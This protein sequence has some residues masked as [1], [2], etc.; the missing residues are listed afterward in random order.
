MD[1]VLWRLDKWNLGAIGAAVSTSKG[2][3]V[4]IFIDC[5]L[6]IYFL[7]S[8]LLMSGFLRQSKDITTLELDNMWIYLIACC[9]MY[10]HILWEYNHLL[11]NIFLHKRSW[12]EWKYFI[13][14]HICL[15][16][17]HIVY[18]FYINAYCYIRQEPV[19]YTVGCH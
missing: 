18:F 1:H 12:G 7:A 2:V 11:P 13:V 5:I 16:D 4:Y 14:F 9:D 17:S 10:D 15:F 6:V 8:S 3:C 19:R